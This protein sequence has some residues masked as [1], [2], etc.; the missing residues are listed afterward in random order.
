MHDVNLILEELYRIVENPTLPNRVI[1]TAQNEIDKINK[2][3]N[4]KKIVLV[5]QI[6]K[7]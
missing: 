3:K 2:E 5:K 1:Q 7:N 6:L 4:N